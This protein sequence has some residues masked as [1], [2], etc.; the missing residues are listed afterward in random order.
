MFT[1]ANLPARIASK[2]TVTDGCWIW[3]GAHNSRGYS[4]LGI[5]GKSHLGHRFVYALAYGPIPKGMTL[6]HMCE[7]KSCVHPYHLNVETGADNTRLRFSRSIEPRK[8]VEPVPA[9]LAFIDAVKAG[10]AKYEAMS[11]ADRVEDDARRH[12]LHVGIGCSCVKAVA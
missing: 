9:L 8:A 12:A 10:H 6:D 2:I 3:T 11:P 7:N 1:L 4:S 5:D